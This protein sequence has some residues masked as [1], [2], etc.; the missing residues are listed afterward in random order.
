MTSL[1]LAASPSAR[2]VR[3]MAVAAATLLVLGMLAGATAPRAQGISYP[4]SSPMIL[5]NVPWQDLRANRHGICNGAFTHVIKNVTASSSLT[6]P[7][8][9]LNEAQACGL[10]VIF[11]FAQTVSSTGI[12]YPTR[13]PRWVNA[14]KAHPNLDGYLTVKEPS[15][16]RIAAWEIRAL[17]RAFKTADPA[18]TVYALFG[19]I[20]HFGDTVNPYQ[21]GMADVVM[22]DWYPVETRSGGCSSYGTYYQPYGP[23][24]YAKV[25]K[26]VAAKTPG[27]PVYVMVQTHKYLA[28]RCH[29]KQ[30]PSK[31]LLWRQVREAFTYGSVQGVAFHTWTNTNYSMDQLRNPTMVGWMKELSAQVRAGTFQ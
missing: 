19:D 6:A 23:K 22:V 4:T 5:Q 27:R 17:Y 18:H 10:K 24:W 14:V 1:T 28:P 20:P 8:N 29:K 16:N 25:R 13:V 3:S 30:L 11:H 2:F 9:Y 31:S 12:V 7:V 21:G 15:W 26:V